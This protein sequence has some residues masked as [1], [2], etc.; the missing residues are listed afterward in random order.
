[1]NWAL[2]GLFIFLIDKNHIF[3]DKY[4]LLTNMVK[5]RLVNYLSSTCLSM[6]R[7]SY[8]HDFEDLS[9]LLLYLIAQQLDKCYKMTLK[10]QK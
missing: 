10:F 7:K 2:Q 1:M 9:I 6:R 5:Y 3:I 4:R 8:Y